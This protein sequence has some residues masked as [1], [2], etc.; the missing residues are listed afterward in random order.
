MK[1]WLTAITSVVAYG[2]KPASVGIESDGGRKQYSDLYATNEVEARNKG[3]FYFAVFKQDYELKFDALPTTGKVDDA[4]I[5]YVGSWYPQKLG[6]TS[7]DLGTGN[8]LQKY[9]KA[10]HGGQSKAQQWEQ[11]H[12]SVSA[13]NSA[14][15]WAGH[16]NG[17]S[18]AAQR[19]IEPK[20]SVKRGETTFS[21]KDI[22]ALLA[23]VHM[24]AKFFFLGGNRCSL[25]QESSLPRRASSSDPSGMNEC[26]DVNPASYH[27]A[28]TNWIGVQKHTVIMDTSSKEQVWNYP[29]FS[30]EY[31]S[32][33]IDKAEAMR[34]I[35][36]TASPTYKFNTA[37]VNFRRVEMKSSHSRAY[38][39]EYTAAELRP[40]DKTQTLTHSYVLE[41]DASG[42]IIGGEWTGTSQQTHP[43][44][45]WV[46]LEPTLG[47][48]SDSA[49]NPNVDPKEVI[50][51]WA[52]SIGADPAN[53]PLDL[54]EPAIAVSWGKFPKFEVDINGGKSGS[55]FL[56][57]PQ[58]MTVL[59]N[60]PLHGEVTLE[61]AIDGLPPLTKSTT[62]D[63]PVSIPLPDLSPGLHSMALEWKRG[64]EVTD[65]Q[66]LRVFAQ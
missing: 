22:K 63:G 49:A 2:C 12:H 29:H 15:A 7:R 57:R 56:G 54:L 39:K 17:Y 44:F 10:F 19:H 36:G 34:L 8:V 59:R 26:D 38:E 46:A 45:I 5:P 1:Y 9:D 21:P 50:K 27:V 35:T 62:G 30:Y 14:A 3:N 40:T 52:E 31:Q 6:G 25:P 65:S 33:E 24:S 41:L 61:I 43:D 37:A 13:S 55:V 53:P 18:A 4:K 66:R 42:K 11:D 51:L 58:K 60:Q 28:L 64:G 20:E 47:D 32:S 48:G 16:C 23:E